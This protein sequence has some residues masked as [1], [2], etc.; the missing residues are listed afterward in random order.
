MCVGVLFLLKAM[1]VSLSRFCSRVVR[2][3]RQI[4]AVHA[5][6]FW[7]AKL[8]GIDRVIVLIADLI[9][10]SKDQARE[11]YERRECS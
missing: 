9:G 5:K 4:S 8:V 2:L 1:I 11:C 3:N 7:R 6:A 10:S